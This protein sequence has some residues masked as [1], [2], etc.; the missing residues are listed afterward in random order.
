M[1]CSLVDFISVQERNGHCPYKVLK[2]SNIIYG[3]EFS[4]YR[5]GKSLSIT[6]TDVILLP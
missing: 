1:H 6:H 5:P 3:L 4:A 2:F